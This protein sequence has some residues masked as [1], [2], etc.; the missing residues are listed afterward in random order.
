MSYALTASLHEGAGNVLMSCFTHWNEPPRASQYCVIHWILEDRAADF[1]LTPFTAKAAAISRSLSCGTGIFRNSLG[2]QA[3]ASLGSFCFCC[4]VVI[5]AEAERFFLIRTSAE[6]HG[7]IACN[8]QSPAYWGLLGCM[9]ASQDVYVSI[10]LSSGDA[11]VKIKPKSPPVLQAVANGLQEEIVS[12]S[13]K[14]SVTSI[15]SEEGGLPALKQAD[16][17]K[18]S[19]NEVLGHGSR[20]YA[21]VDSRARGLQTAVGAVGVDTDAI[22]HPDGAAG[23]DFEDQVPVTN[24][25]LVD[26]PLSDGEKS[27][28][29]AG[30]A[31]RDANGGLQEAQAEGTTGRGV[32]EIELVR[33]ASLRGSDAAAQVSVEIGQEVKDAVG[34]ESVAQA[35]QEAERRTSRRE[36]SRSG[37]SSRSFSGSPNGSLGESPFMRART[38]NGGGEF[39]FVTPA[40]QPFEGLLYYDSIDSRGHPVVVVNT[41]ALPRMPFGVTRARTAALNYMRETLEP[42]VNRGPYVLIFTSFQVIGD[43]RH[44]PPPRPQ[45]R[46]TLSSGASTASNRVRICAMRLL[47]S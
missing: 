19:A 22:A 30:D 15:A 37:S 4:V 27:D 10:D 17:H 47:W 24:I 41:G 16:V 45:G 31:A 20:G 29:E 13:A 44:I 33:P 28:S 5:A 8:K 7:G 39:P 32:E 34:M 38:A 9:D 36:R 18:P 43:T 3:R 25:E 35:L 6:E 11:Q 23:A 46:C 40:K 2:F 12:A 42:V 21:V 1:S 14:D 26:V